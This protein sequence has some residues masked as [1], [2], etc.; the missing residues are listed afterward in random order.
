VVTE[1]KFLPFVIVNV[2]ST[3]AFTQKQDNPLFNLQFSGKY[4]RQ[5]KKKKLTT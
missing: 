5:K 4:P 2:D 3:A 1:H